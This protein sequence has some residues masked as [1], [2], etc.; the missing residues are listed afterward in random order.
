[1]FFDAKNL[2]DNTQSKLQETIE[3][4]INEQKD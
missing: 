4:K 2:T 1:M 3:Q